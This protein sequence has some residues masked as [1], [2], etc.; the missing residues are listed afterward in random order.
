MIAV[1]GTDLR[2]AHSSKHKKCRHL[3][4]CIS[5]ITKQTWV[6]LFAVQRVTYS[7]LNKKETYIIDYRGAYSKNQKWFAYFLP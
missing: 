3:K 4:L 5:V 6:I 2:R 1:I 7:L